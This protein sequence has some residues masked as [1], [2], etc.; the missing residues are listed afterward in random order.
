M[1]EYKI[2][3]NEH[4]NKI[5]SVDNHPIA[6]IYDDMYTDLLLNAKNNRNELAQVKLDK[7]E[8]LEALTKVRLELEK[9]QTWN[10]QGWKQNAIA[11]SIVTKIV[12]MIKEAEG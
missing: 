1:N 8:L 11:P 3:T 6:L 4:G 7:A 2:E 10:G 9:H 5:M 12:T